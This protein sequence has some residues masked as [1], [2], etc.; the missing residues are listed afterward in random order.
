MKLFVAPFAPN[1]LRVLVV[2]REKGIAAEHVDV[3]G[4][5]PGEYA[6][7]NPLGQVPSLMLDDG[8]VMTESRTICEYLDSISGAPFLFGSN[9]LERARIGQWERRA[10]MGLL[11]P[12]IE[13]GHH[14][15]PMFAGRLTQFPEW[16]QT[17]VPRA[18]RV[19]DLVAAQLERSE[20]L[21]GDTLSAADLT[22]ALGYLQLVGMGA[23]PA[24]ADGALA[25]W[26]RRLFNRDSFA[27][28]RE[29]IAAFRPD[30]LAQFAVHDEEAV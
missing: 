9:P 6:A 12:A 19:L 4:L 29:L 18:E 1:P 30:L 20:Y 16:A 14:S 10:E 17:L 8:E 26:A 11:N 3:T 27:P 21:V 22:A 13:Y 2:M 15:M 24:R 25:A 23:V 5:A 7:I 28:V